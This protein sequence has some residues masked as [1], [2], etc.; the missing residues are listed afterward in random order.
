MDTYK[1]RYVYKGKLIGRYFN[2]NG[3]ATPYK[4]QLNDK[5]KQCN[6]EKK[7]QEEFKIKYP[8]CNMEWSAETGSRVWCSQNS[9]GVVRDWSGV[10]RKFFSP[11]TSEPQCVC[12]N[13]IK[14]FP[15]AQFKEYENCLPN[16]AS[17]KT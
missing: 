3:E 5:L 4:K 12:V 6:L 10:P 14:P 9:G 2:T 13:L 11:G 8:P 16:S 7:T 17:C 15:A 1:T